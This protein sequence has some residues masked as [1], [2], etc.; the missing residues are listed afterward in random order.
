MTEKTWG[1]FELLAAHQGEVPD[2]FVIRRRIA[3]AMQQLSERLIRV[4]AE[5]A[6]LEQWAGTLEEL[7]EQVGTPPRRN[8]RE[9]NRR[10][11]TGQA[12]SFDVFDMMDYDPM[13]GLSIRLRRSCAGSVN[14]PMALKVSFVWASTIRARPAAYTAALLPGFLMPCCHAPCMLR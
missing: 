6:D 3:T 10:L 5:D 1:P 14:L 2:T 4:E 9:A 13:G 8:T 11:F 7:V 12:S